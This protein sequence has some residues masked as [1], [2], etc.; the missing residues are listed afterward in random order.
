MVL[1]HQPL[2]ILQQECWYPSGT[3]N[4]A[5]SAIQAAGLPTMFGLVCTS[6][7]LLFA[8]APKQNS[9]RRAFLFVYKVSMV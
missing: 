9:S 2:Y 4:P 1:F 5:C 3:V 7:V 6:T 8:L